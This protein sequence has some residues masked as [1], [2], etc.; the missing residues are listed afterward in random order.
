MA[1]VKVRSQHQITI[2]ARIAESADIKKDDVLEI[3]CKNGVLTL[4]PVSGVARKKSAMSYAGIARGVWGD[5]VQ[6]IEA[7]LEQNRES[8]ER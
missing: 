4:K 1:Q 5:T 8:W 2:P 3:T 6:E 7:E